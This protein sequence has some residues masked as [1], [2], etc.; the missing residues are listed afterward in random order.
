MDKIPIS[1]QFISLAGMESSANFAWS[2]SSGKRIFDVVFASL[3]VIGTAPLMLLA[4]A[5]IKCSSRGPVIF[6]QT[7]VGQYG[8]LFQLLK[9]RTMVHNRQ[10]QGPGLTQKGDP[11]IF[12][13]GRFLRHWKLDEL[14]QF[15]NVVR[16]DMSLVGPRP[17]LPEY[18]ASL[19]GAE[20]QVF[21]VRPGI[22]GSATVQLR[23]EEEL[24]AQIP[25][26]ELANFYTSRLLPEKIRIDVAYA[27]DANLF[28]DVKVLLRTVASIL[29]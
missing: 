21:S 1:S 9:F 2:R 13:V 6:R 5:L 11:R 29:R 14:P 15:V 16:G 17:D 24:L 4:A 22:T 25:P 7:R 27:R 18:M 26:A 12:P 8:K 19:S 20:R 10:D 23:Q 28:S 3:L